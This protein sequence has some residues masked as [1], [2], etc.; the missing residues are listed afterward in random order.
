MSLGPRTIWLECR[1]TRPT[2]RHKIMLRTLIL[3]FF[4]YVILEMATLIGLGRM[5]GVFPTIA[6]V[7]GAGIAGAWLA[8][9]QGLQS[10][11]RMRSKM[12]AGAIPAAEMTDGLLIGL[13]I[14]LLIIPG[15]LGDIVGLALLFPPTRAFIRY[16]F[17]AKFAK[18]ASFTRFTAT[19][20]SA[21]GAG[22][23]TV[24]GDR[25][26]DARVIETRVVDD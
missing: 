20:P 12:A 26:I 25:I 2:V 14:V 8:R 3:I 18:Q 17:T 5:L 23:G 21:A 1:V 11:L 16:A 7:L 24:R 22:S 10:A 9:R 6:L 19:Q 4:G 13:A 15:V